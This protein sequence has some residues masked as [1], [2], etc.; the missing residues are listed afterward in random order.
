MPLRRQL[1]ALIATSGFVGC[2]MPTEPI[3]LAVNVQ[4]VELTSEAELRAW[5]FTPTIEGGSGVRIRGLGQFGCGSGVGA[6]I[7]RDDHLR[8]MIGP[9]LKPDICPAYYATWRPFEATVQNLPPGSYRVRVVVAGQSGQAE[10]TVR[11]LP[12]SG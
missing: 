4:F 12:P 3:A 9:T 7:L 6:A 1:V 8:V 5:P 11:V 2:A 10:F